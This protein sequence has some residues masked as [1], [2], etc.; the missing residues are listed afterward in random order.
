MHN[1]LREMS[2]ESYTPERCI[3]FENNS[4]EISFV[5]WRDERL[6]LLSDLR[7]N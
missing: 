4:D 5:A 7:A 3:D 2:R 1:M 6:A